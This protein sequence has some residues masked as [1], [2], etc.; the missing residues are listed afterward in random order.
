VRTPFRCF[1]V[2]AFV[3]ALAQ[4][5]PAQDAAQLLHRVVDTYKRIPSYHFESESEGGLTTDWTKSW[6]RGHSIVA[7]EPG[8]H[9][10]FETVDQSGRYVVVSD[11]KTL[12]RAIGAMHEYSRTPLAGAVLEVTGGGSEGQLALRRL[13]MAIERY[14]KLEENLL[15][16]QQLR[17]EHMD[18]NGTDLLCTVVRADYSAPRGAEGIH[19]MTRTFWI[20]GVRNLIVQE[21]SVT[22][23][24]LMPNMPYE[25][26]ESRHRTRYTTMI[27][28]EPLPDALFAYAPPANYREMDKL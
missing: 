14:W 11:G 19:S 16:A 10:R 8:N 22:T 25:Y 23:G 28:G 24:N 4:P 13:K 6:D 12:W 20:D 15:A 7:V 21:E 18:V 3:T 26:A 2:S 27:T 9:V 17:V 5:I 1:C